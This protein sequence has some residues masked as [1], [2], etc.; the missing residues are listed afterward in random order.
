[1]TDALWSEISM[2]L[3]TARNYWL[4][5]TGSTGAPHVAPVWG[6]VV[7]DTLYLYSTRESVKARNLARDP[8]AVVHLESGDTVCIVHGEVV[9]EGVPSQ[10]PHILEALAGKYAHA[11]DQQYLPSADPSF[12]VL[13][14]LRPRRAMLW[15]L[16]DY[17]GSQLRW[18]LEPIGP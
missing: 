10:H 15:S 6:A 11:D 9:D 12:D 17:E 2:R 7:A 4:A 3:S 1:M 16:D 8:R 5:T 13:Y 18:A 14:G